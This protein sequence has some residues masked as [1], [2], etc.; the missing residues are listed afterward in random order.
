MADR[1]GTVKFLTTK[2]IAAG[3]EDIIQDAKQFIIII[4]PYVKVDKTYID[5]LHEADR[6]GIAIQIVFGKKDM[7]D[8]EKDKFRDFRRLEV[9][10]L[11]NLHAKCYMNES[12]AIIT[13][14]NLYGYS[15]EHNREMGIEICREDNAVLFENIIK[16]AFSIY[17]A[18]ERVT[19]SQENKHSGFFDF[20]KH[21]ERRTNERYRSGYCIRCGGKIN[22]NPYY[23]LCDEC[24]QVWSQFSNVEY[25]ENYCHR[26]GREV[27]GSRERQ[28]D[29]AHPLCTDCED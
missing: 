1:S 8:F 4:C 13:S 3:I 23:P 20:T 27:W 17:S 7:R 9:K 10:F 15:E 19:L 11:E 28:V 21:A 26:C 22:F 24:Y 5:R 29:Y 18:A 2:G 12:T 25:Q 14:M 16:E 6:K